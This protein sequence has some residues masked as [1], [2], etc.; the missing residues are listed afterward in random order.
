MHIYIFGP[1]PL[2]WNFLQISQLSIR[3]GAHKLFR[4]FLDFSF[5]DCNFVKNVAPPS[6]KNE[7]YVVHVKEQSIV[8]K[9]L[10]TA[11]KSTNKPSHNRCLNY[12]PYAQA[13]Q[14][15]HTKTPIS[16]S[17]AGA[18]AD[19]AQTL[20]ADRE[21]RA[22]HKRCQSFF[23]PT[24]SFSYRGENADFW[25]LTHWVNLIPVGYHGN[26]P[27]TRRMYWRRA[28]IQNGQAP[29]DAIVL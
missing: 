11:S 9:T 25:P 18:R 2:Q 23:D 4:R 5:F 12:V 26:L 14:A 1:K 19:L 20:H 17:T 22:H 3:S 24:H 13:V 6:D 27:V 28:S 15:W 7:N 21:R 16:A 8:K 29:G 10:K